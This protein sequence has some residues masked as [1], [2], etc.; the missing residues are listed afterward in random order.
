MHREWLA[1]HAW[2]GAAILLALPAIA[3][4]LIVAASK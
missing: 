4:L 3:S 1:R 2:I